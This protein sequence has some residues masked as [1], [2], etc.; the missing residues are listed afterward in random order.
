M[1]VQ[2]LVQRRR[3]HGFPWQPQ[4][5]RYEA[6][7]AALARMGPCGCPMP[8]VSVLGLTVVGASQHGIDRASP[9]SRSN[10]HRRLSRVVRWRS[11]SATPAQSTV[12]VRRPGTHAVELR[13]AAALELT[14]WPA[15][16]TKVADRHHHP[17]LVL[18]S[19]IHGY[20]HM[21]ATA[22]LSNQ[23]IVNARGPDGVTPLV[24]ACQH[25]QLD[26]I[27]SLLELVRGACTHAPCPLLQYRA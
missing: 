22:A 8:G 25:G 6:L 5:R 15:V 1:S 2:Q 18:W 21:I 4:W 10:C 27:N 7:G 13:L 19:A 11:A 20:S 14:T 23:D 24:L 9:S 3:H 12:L 16:C 26:T 17:E